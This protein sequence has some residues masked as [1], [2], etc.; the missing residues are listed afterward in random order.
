[1][2]VFGT[3]GI[4]VRHLSIPSSVIAMIRGFVGMF[5]LL[6][7]MFATRKKISFSEIK[8]KAVPLF[9]SGGFIGINWILLFESYRYTTVATATLCYYLAPIFVILASPI[10]L[11]EKM[12]A[13]KLICV[14]TALMG[15]VFVSGINDISKISFSSEIKGILFG[16]GAA[17]FYA[18]VVLLNRGLKDVP[19]YDKTFIQ[20]GSAAVVI[21]PY[22]LLTENMG[23]IDFSAKTVILLL[24]MGIVHTG[25]SYAL[26]FNAIGNIPSHTVAIFSY[27]DPIVAIILSALFLNEPMGIAEIIGA[28]LI[29]GAAFISEL[30]DKK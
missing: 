16:V 29:L 9:I 21:L 6:A 3:I 20:L 19:T 25:I 26:Y 1:M 5:F 13:K 28:V 11:K 7:I 24:V 17:I 2:T 12:T 30:P 27:I 22:T 4:F 14:F 18:S 23:A 15:M 8:K 10:F